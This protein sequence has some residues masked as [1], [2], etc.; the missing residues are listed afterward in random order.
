MNQMKI[1]A[2]SFNPIANIYHEVRPGYPKEMYSQISKYKK[3]SFESKIL[4]IG[5]GTGIAT[6]EL[7]ENFNPNITVV[8]PC[9][10]FFKILQKRFLGNHKIRIV[11]ETFEKF[12]NY[13]CLYDGIF[14]ATSFHWLDSNIKC[15]KSY[16][17]LNNHGLLVIYWNNYLIQ[18]DTVKNNIKEIYDK[19]G[20]PLEM[21]KG[22]EKIIEEKINKRR[23]EI[24][25]C[26]LFQILEHKLYE[27]VIS[28]TPDKF[29]K[30][31]KTFADQ[32]LEKVPAI[33]SFFKEMQ[34]FTDDLNKQIDI[35]VIT[36]LE[37]ASK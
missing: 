10:D 29:L 21:V 30:L 33:E 37:I 34:K 20:M 2:Q 24:E 35:K 31:I 7:S 23:K 18:N 3:F 25:N 1:D 12:D 36:N 5:A 16:E 9:V 14:S 15:E 8:E 26:S 32:P 13:Q 19:Y 11:N 22:T 4:E 28:Y 17:M 27:R 6:D